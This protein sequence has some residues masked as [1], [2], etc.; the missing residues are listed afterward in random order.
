M[1]NLTSL[2]CSKITFI[3]RYDL[4]LIVDCFPSLEELVLMAERSCTYYN[5]TRNFG[6]VLHD[7]N[8]FL[9]LPKLCKIRLYG[10][11]VRSQFINYLRTSR[12]P[13]TNEKNKLDHIDTA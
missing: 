8:Q 13:F 11:F 7:H 1:K 12:G 3:H 10:I 5:A 6:F 2:T 4:L 9:A